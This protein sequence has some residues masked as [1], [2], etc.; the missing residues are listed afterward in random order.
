MYEL[1]GPPTR[2][3]GL[4]WGGDFKSLFDAPHIEIQPHQLFEGDRRKGSAIVW[5]TYLRL[6][7]TYTG[8]MDGLFG[9]MSQDALEAATGSRVRNRTTYRQLFEK[10]GRLTVQDI[11]PTEMNLAA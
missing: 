10:F 3:A 4:K 11:L 1:I 9:P 2:E 6:A 8:K 7:G 5:Q